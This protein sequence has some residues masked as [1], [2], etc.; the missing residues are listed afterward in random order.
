M[1][2][3]EGGKEGMRDGA[4]EILDFEGRM[5]LVWFGEWRFNLEG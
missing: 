2:L 3:E 4:V 5:G 1:G